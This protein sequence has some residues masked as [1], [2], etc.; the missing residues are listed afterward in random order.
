M[1]YDSMLEFLKFGPVRTQ[2]GRTR[3]VVP[4]KWR[5]TCKLHLELLED[6]TLPSTLTVL[7]NHDSGAGSL[8]DLLA[9]AHDGDMIR[10]DHHLA[11]RT[12]TLSSG[13]LVIDKS[14]DI[15]GLGAN[16]LTVSGHDMSRVFDIIDGG[17]HVAIT[18]LTIADGK[19]TQGAGIHNTGTLTVANV[20]LADNRAIGAPGD[21]GEG[22][23]IFNEMG[24]TLSISG[25]RFLHNQ[26]LGGAPDATGNA[27]NGL[28]GAIANFGGRA[29]VGHSTF[30]D[31]QAVGTD[32]G[33]GDHSSTGTGPA[34]DVVHSTG[35]GGAIANEDGGTLV[36]T[37]STLADNLARGGLRPTSA[38]GVGFGEGGAIRNDAT[39]TVSHSAFTGN[40]G[41]GGDGVPGVSGGNGTAG[42]ILNGF[43][44]NSSI[45]GCTLAGNV[46]IAGGGGSGA[47]GGAG[48]GGAIL[49]VSTLVLTQST[50]ARNRT[51][52]GAGGAGAAGGN[53]TGGGILNTANMESAFLTVTDTTIRDNQA[54][55]GNGGA[56]GNGGI[57]SG[58]GIETH[59]PATPGFNAEATVTHST[60]VGNQ[61]IGG[62]GGGTGTGGVG[63][64]GGIANIGNVS[65]ATLT[66]SDSTFRDNRA[67][68]GVGGSGG[69]GLGGGIDNET[70]ADLTLTDSTLS[71]NRATGGD[72]GRGDGLGGG[73]YVSGGTVTIWDSTITRNQ[74][75]GGEGGTDGQ[76]VGGGLYN[77]AG[78]VRV[79]GTRINHNHASTSGDDIFGDI[80]YF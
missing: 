68:G 79:H 38:F 21:D 13:E 61:A 15:V 31:N 27:G 3:S 10:F 75:D 49:N 72:G 80:E 16:H 55:G 50:L 9:V 30:A 28:G 41:I 65:S 35:T 63:R 26:A 60:I 1:W 17:A 18:G 48:G 22:G 43:L 62:A 11:G 45:S 33:P 37:D 47:A 40:Q 12:I 7:N 4:R 51:T 52:G 34:P 2:A 54:F 74:A 66:V 70:D 36:V 19:A 59:V 25:A 46:T 71:G 53:G 39:L 20:T 73:V 32:S 6:R 23:A 14:V 77:A 42:A 24:A 44:G 29:T 69:N 78:A 56:G 76:G 67:I 8:R 58:G 64:G 5:A 57:G